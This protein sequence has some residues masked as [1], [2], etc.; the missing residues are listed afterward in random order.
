MG[1][2]GFLG[3][4]ELLVMIAALRVGHGAYAVN[5]REEI[6]SRTGRSISRGAVYVTLDRL[7]RKGLLRTLMSEPTAARGGKAKRLYRVS[8]SGLAAI[9]ESQMMLS[10]ML[11]GVGPLVD[12]S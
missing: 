9:R 1:G 3:E 8:P 7:V 10:E 4:F 11:R 5:I 2:Q 6:E 12:G